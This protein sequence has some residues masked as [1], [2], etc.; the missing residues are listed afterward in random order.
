VQT[1][2]ALASVYANLGALEQGIETARLAL[3]WAESHLPML[4]PY[5][6]A[7]LAQ[8]HLQSGNSAEAAAAADAS[9]IDPA[10]SHPLSVITAASAQCR[11]A[12]ARGDDTRAIEV[13]GELLA[14][15]REYGA[16]PYIPDVLYWL[17]QAHLAGGQAGAARER[18]LQARAEAEA[19]GS[20]HSLWPILIALSELEAR[21]GNAAESQTLRGQ[22]RE[23][24]D[25][26][27]DHT[28]TPELRA[29]FLNL[30]DV[31]KVTSDG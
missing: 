31:R 29:S 26:I 10:T 2:A 12:L 22:A 7:T 30:P 4:R 19:L 6:L 13:G 20:R 28:G 27:A 9:E 24:V 18:L 23:I 25:Y 1:R 11:L 8:I 17:G 14:R 16:R 15:L 3:A 5:V 21:C